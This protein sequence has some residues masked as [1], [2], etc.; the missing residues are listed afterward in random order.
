MIKNPWIILLLLYL[1]PLTSSA[2]T[3]TIKDK[4]SFDLGITRGGNLHLW[5]IVKVI[6]TPGYKNTEILFTLYQN[7]KNYKDTMRHAHFLPVFWYDSNTNNNQFKLFTTYYPSVFAYQKD[8]R[9]HTTSYRFIDIAPEISLLNFTTSNDGNYLKNSIFFFLWYKND[10]INKRSHFV[11]FPVY[12]H[13]ATP[14]SKSSTLFPIYSYGAYNNLQTKYTIVTPLF[15]RFSYPNLQ[16]KTVLFPLY[17]NN[18]SKD[19][20][21]IYNKTTLFPLYWRYRDPAF[22]NTV[23]FPLF[24]QYHNPNYKSTTL[25]PLYASGKDKKNTSGF[26]IITPLFWSTYNKKGT[27]TMLLPFWVKRKSYINYQ[28]SKDTLI[29][30]YVFPFYTSQTSLSENITRRTF[31]PFY[32]RYKSTFKKN[33]TIFPLIWKRD[34]SHNK[35]FSIFPL[36]SQGTKNKWPKNQKYFSIAYLYWHTTFNESAKK[37]KRDILFPIWWHSKVTYDKLGTDKYNVIFPLWWSFS[38][39]SDKSKSKVLF[40]FVWYFNNPYNKSIAIMPFFAYGQS[41]TDTAKKHFAITPL[42]WHFETKNSKSNFLFPIFWQKKSTTRKYTTIFPLWWSKNTQRRSSKVL[43]PIWWSYTN[44]YY[45]TKKQVLFPLVWNIHK[46]NYHTFAFFPMFSFGKSVKDSTH[47]HLVITPL[48]WQVKKGGS[49]TNVFFPLWWHK[50]T[51]YIKRNVIF[52]LWW[53]HYNKTLENR[54]RVLFPIIWSYQNRRYNSLTF[55][56][57]FSYSQS[58]DKKV[59]YTAIT[60]LYWQFKNLDMKG[61]ILFPVLWQIEKPNK[62]TSVVFPLYWSFKSY[63]DTTKVIFP[64]SYSFKGRYNKTYLFFP[65]YL[66]NKNRLNGNTLKVFTPL[67]WHYKSAKKKTTVVFPLI[68]SFN[69]AKYKSFTF[70]PFFSYGKSKTNTNRHLV[71]TPLFW[72]IHRNGQH[73][74]HVAPLFTY[75]SDTVGNKDFSLLYFLY[76]HHHTATT[77][78]SSFLWPLCEYRK[79]TASKEF[80]FAPLIWYKRSP[81]TKYTA[82]LPFVYSSHI[83]NKKQVNI[84]WQLY[85]H[86]TVDS[87]VKKS[88]Y[89]FKSV[90]ANRYANNDHE[91]RFLYFVYVKKKVE[92]KKEISVFPFYQ[93]YSDSTI[94]YKSKTYCLGL[95]TR[96]SRAIPNTT[97]TYKEEK[98]LWFIRLRSNYKSLKAQGIEIDRKKKKG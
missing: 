5:P 80:R 37:G 66:K 73:K 54:T 71:I 92:G 31:F 33:W 41:K 63:Y 83:G 82:I 27:T 74:V 40:P 60:P 97:K 59:A 1:C 32:W 50:N 18:R 58:K 62:K 91:Y 3:D 44:Y 14:N 39:E 72:N 34:D 76:R 55:F 87:T 53:S 46:K 35:S 67:A 22:R 30:N 28:Y 38:S 89:L 88:S 42:F 70:A 68:Y 85:A 29:T 52:P 84:L 93:Q 65:L 78:Q 45:K 36:Y 49:T 15:W 57:L 61:R 64:L 81:Q 47:R 7:K 94:G 13:F 6:K 8:Y 75:K 2:Q 79:D 24:W 12:W 10:K 26:R 43:F 17:F 16:T 23:I 25:F 20:A 98:I 9:K 86:Q 95:Y 19:S 56:P 69:T 11:T 48:F 77:T 21:N 90:I 4:L 96:F 51:P